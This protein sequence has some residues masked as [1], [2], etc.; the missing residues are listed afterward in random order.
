ML[1]TKNK[2]LFEGEGER[3]I[4]IFFFSLFF[5]YDF[6][7][8][9]K[10]FQDFVPPEHPPNSPQPLEY[11]PFFDNTYLAVAASL[12]GG[13]VL[14]AFVRTVQQWSLELGFQVPQCELVFL[15]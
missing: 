4:I 7:L 15:M 13:N 10:T 1:K 3:K 2:K 8:I 6:N 14:A 11:F 9:C 5:G 12:N